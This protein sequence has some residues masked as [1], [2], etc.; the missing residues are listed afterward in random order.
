MSS[1]TDVSMR[2]RAVPRIGL[3]T[4]SLNGAAGVAA[5]VDALEA[6]YRH[7]DTAPI[8]GNEGTVGGALAEAGLPAAEVFVSTKV[9][10]DS[11]APAQLRASAE[12]SREL[13]GREQLDLLLL[14]WPPQDQTELPPALETLQALRAEGIVAEFGVSNFTPT[15]LLESLRAAPELAAIQVE[16]HPHLHQRRL[17]ALADEHDLLL[18]AYAPLGSGRDVLED[19]LLAEIAAAHAATPA[20]V[21]LAWLVARPHVTALPRSANSERRA[22]NL[23]A[24]QLQLSDEERE[25]LD[26]RADE[27]HARYFPPPYDPP[28]W[29]D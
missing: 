2:G 10:V 17:L 20:Q 12:R 11:F 24:A 4:W 22:A 5:I 14:H 6:G 15:Q 19:P 16:F 21:A 8:Y 27:R 28:H 3:G 18:Q 13:L 29:E 23:A 1:S 7:L 25:R 9:W 26:A